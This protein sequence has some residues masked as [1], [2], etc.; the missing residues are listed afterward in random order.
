MQEIIRILKRLIIMHGSYYD[1]KEQRQITNVRQFAILSRDDRMYICAIPKRGCLLQPL[2]IDNGGCVVK[3]RYS[4]A[5]TVSDGV[6]QGISLH[7]R[8][9]EYNA[10]N[11]IYPQAGVF[12]HGLDLWTSNELFEV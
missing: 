1:E 11:S 8:L 6:K 4:I 2:E 9:S 12:T 5:G 7:D 3:R 10:L